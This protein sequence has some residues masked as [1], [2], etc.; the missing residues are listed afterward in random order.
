MKADE[1]LKPKE[2]ELGFE[3][4]LRHFDRYRSCLKL[5]GRQ[6]KK[7]SWLDCSC[8]SGYGT[9]YLSNFASFVDGVDIF[10]PIVEYARETYLASNTAFHTEIP[11]KTYNAIVCIE[12]IEHMPKD[13][14][15][16]F[17]RNLKTRLTDDGDLVITTIIREETNEDPI[18]QFHHIEYSLTD[19]VDVLR[20]GGFEILEKQLITATFTDGET[21]DN[22]FFK[23]KKQKGY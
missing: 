6:G 17:L 23:C 18:N 12:T 20:E 1:R 4:T 10:P 8:G 13:A 15:I 14:A 11:E 3:P 21:K 9:N 22:G 7:E 16:A 19:F 2:F 5:L